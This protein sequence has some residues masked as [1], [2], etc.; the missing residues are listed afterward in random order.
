MEYLGLRVDT[1]RGLISKDIQDLKTRGLAAVHTL[2]NHM[3]F[4]LGLDPKFISTLYDTYVR[5][6]I[7]YGS[8]LL[9]TSERN[10]LTALGDYLL[11][12]TY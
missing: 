1:V 10:P 12:R 5:S 11:L 9:L 2:L 7:S 3:W 8:E 6:I 4:S